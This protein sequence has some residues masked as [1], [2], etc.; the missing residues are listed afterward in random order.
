MTIPFVKDPKAALEA[1]KE[2]GRLVL[3]AAVSAGLSSGVAALNL[4][5]DPIILVGLSTF[6][7]FIGKAWDKYIHKSDANG[8]TTGLT[9]F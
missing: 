3:I 9:G 2:F 6:L 5:H 1:L 7:T 8:V 4:I